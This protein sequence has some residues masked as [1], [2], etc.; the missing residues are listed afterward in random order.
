[1][2]NPTV[3][4]FYSLSSLLRE[5]WVPFSRYL[6]NSVL[7]SG[8]GTLG[9]VIFSSL[10]AYRIAKF[11]FPGR[12]LYF[13]IVTMSLMFSSAV[14]SIANFLIMSRLNMID[15]YWAIIVPA[16]GSSLGLFL[17][18]QF[19][20]QMVP[21]ALIEAAQID[22]AGEWM[23]FSRIVMP[24]VKPAWFTLIIF[25]FKDIWNST[26]SNLIFMRISSLP[27]ALGNI[28]AGGISRAVLRRRFRLLSYSAGSG[29]IFSQTTFWKPCQLPE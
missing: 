10:A 13:S 9:N 16:C 6:F 24:V 29:F 20:E 4:N 5:S 1:M 2:Q 21:D 7:I 26:G 18:K 17:M 27:S 8:L 12:K 25:C 14:T 22:G 23:I 15:T 19:M 28:V 11:E 3:M